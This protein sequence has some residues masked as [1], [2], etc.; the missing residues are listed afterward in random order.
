MKISFHVSDR[1]AENSAIVEGH[2]I[3][4]GYVDIHVH[5]G[6][7]ADYMDGSLDAVLAANRAHG[8][9]GTTTIFPTTTTGTPEEIERMLDACAK[10]RASW[11]VADGSRIGGIHYYGPYFATEKVGC[12]SPEGR[13][14]PDA[15]EYRRA[16]ATGLIRVATCAAELPGS[17]EF[18]R[19]AFAAGCLV[20][21]GHSNATWTEMEA[22]F[23][24]GVR[25]VDHFWNAM[26]SVASVRARLGT[27]AQGSM[28][29]FVLAYRDMS[30]EVIADG[31]HLAPE[32]LNFAFQM[33]GPERLCLVTDANRA[34]D[35][36]PGRYRFGPEQT[37]VW[38]ESDGN[39]GF[40]PNGGLAS[41]VVGMDHMVRHMAAHT[42]ATIADTVRMASLTPAE[43]CGMSD[44]IGSLEAGKLADILILDE[45]LNVQRAYIGGERFFSA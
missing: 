20:T 9:H 17:T 19:A 8:R 43:R 24:A 23:A 22:A 44:R 31:R 13:R 4:P 41:S 28:E 37:G 5:G 26:S 14:D 38:I 39:V 10:A 2:Y 32:L 45:N 40:I 30:T 25:H 27:P 29:Q 15:E 7:G 18:Y 36:P 3:G 11:S 1:P 16:L 34:L 35:M 12:H 42:T 6:A 33:K 21:C